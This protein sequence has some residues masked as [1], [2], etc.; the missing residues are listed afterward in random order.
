MIIC[1]R[2]FLFFFSRA[3]IHNALASVPYARADA[4]GHV[5]TPL[6]TD[7]RGSGLSAES[8]SN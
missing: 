2:F 8:D 5:Y 7:L 4:A 3:A 6:E 1:H